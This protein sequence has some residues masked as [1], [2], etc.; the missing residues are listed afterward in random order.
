MSF[1]LS[2]RV[3]KIGEFQKVTDSFA[4]QKFRIE[5]EEQFPQ[6][7]EFQAVNDR[8]NLLQDIRIGDAVTI[9]FDIRGR[10]WAKE[11]RE[12]NMTT[13]NVWKVEK[14]GSEQPA[15]TAQ[16]APQAAPVDDDDSL[17]F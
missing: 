12:G 5:T 9:H 15:P 1:S 11:G 14:Q 7:I 13:L 4:V 2:G 8:C 10:D 17:P 6:K 3:Y 16:S